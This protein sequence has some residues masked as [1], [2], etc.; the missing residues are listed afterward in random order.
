MSQIARCPACKTM[1]KVVADQ[2][3]IAQGWVRCGQCGEVFDA[4]VPFVSDAAAEQ[5]LEQAPLHER[6]EDTQPGLDAGEALQEIEPQEIEKPPPST[7]LLDESPAEQAVM[8]ASRPVEEATPDAAPSSEALPVA[9]LLEHPALEMP[10]R[11]AAEPDTASEVSFVRD[12]RRKEFWK[13][14]LIR[15]ALGL[16]FL[17]LLSALALQWMVRQKD[18]LAALHPR[19][20]P[21]LEALCTPLG[22]EI[23]PLRR[24]GSLAIDSSSFTKT[25]ID[26]Y[27]LSFVLKNNDVTTLEIP[28]VEVTLTDSRDQALV[29]R[30]VKPGQ[31]GA[32]AATLGAHLELSGAMSLRVS[33]ES[34]PTGSPSQ[35]AL[36]PVTGYRLLAF[37]P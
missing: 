16:L 15:A 27:R 13:T 4:S 11:K 28:A 31:F 14:P 21:L 33:D 30:V 20:V 23:R 25:G 1:F 22:C 12:A 26:T 17:L 35:A 32:V 29:R 7:V 34:A 2:L 36:L 6:V 18:V 3:K 9:A 8:A 24:I 37:Y 5:V 10:E 19:L